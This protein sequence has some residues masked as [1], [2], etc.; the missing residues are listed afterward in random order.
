MLM[1]KRKG[2]PSLV[3]SRIRF[4]YLQS[5]GVP[6]SPIKKKKTKTDLPQPPSLNLEKY[7][8]VDRTAAINRV[9]EDGERARK[10]SDLLGLLDR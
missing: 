8:D 9:Y 3:G 7:T 1:M 5:K 6:I 2:R 4:Y 10:L